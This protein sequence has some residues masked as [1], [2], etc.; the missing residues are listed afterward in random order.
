MPISTE[1]ND[2]FLT[3]DDITI[4]ALL[5]DDTALRKRYTDVAKKY[6]DRYTFGLQT[7][8]GPS[9]L[10]CQ[11][12]PDG[13]AYEL[14]D[15]SR[16]SSIEGFVRGCG[17]PLVREMSRR[18]ET[19]IMQVRKPTCP[20]PAFC[21]DGLILAQTGKSIVHYIPSSDAD[22][23]AYT[24][25]IR[26][27]AKKYA[28]FLVFVTVDGEEYPDMAASLGHESNAKGV[29][30]VQNS[31][32]GEVYPWDG[33]ISA[34]EVEGFILKISKGEVKAWDGRQRGGQDAEAAH[35]EL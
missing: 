6:N 22:K 3:S 2:T 32:T 21:S 34:E 10:K 23:E 29:L 30:S 5:P 8:D 7:T 16:V 15:L 28:E 33:G 1:I 27:L 26:S 35:D 12:N 24:F 11:N 20:I 4:L 13:L 14:A 17:A 18:S 9:G 31:R 19:S 25:A